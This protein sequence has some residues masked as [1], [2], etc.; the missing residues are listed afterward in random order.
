M[1]SGEYELGRDFPHLEKVAEEALRQ[2]DRRPAERLCDMYSK[3]AC[4]AGHKH[5]AIAKEKARRIRALLRATIA[6]GLPVSDL[7]TPETVVKARYVNDPLARMKLT[8]RQARAAGEIRAVYEGIVRA[9]FARVRPTDAIQVDISR[10]ALDPVDWLPERLAQA[11]SLRYLP[12]VKRQG[13]ERM[14]LVIS[15]LVDGMSLRWLAERFG[16]DRR[17][18]GK[19][20]RT[21]LDDYGA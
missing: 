3:E 4:R 19:A 18:L 21:A 10:K 20:L 5:A 11:R 1:I 15:V 16:A 2:G 8:A 7:P 9:L 6:S 12:W 14:G 17:V 13:R